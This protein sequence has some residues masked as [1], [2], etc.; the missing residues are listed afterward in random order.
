[1]F[2]WR[3]VISI[4][5]MFKN[6][7]LYLIFHW[8]YSFWSSSYKEWDSK[9]TNSNNLEVCGAW[10][11]AD[12]WEEKKLKVNTTWQG[13]DQEMKASV[14]PM[15]SLNSLLEFVFYLYKLFDLQVSKNKDISQVIIS[16]T[17]E[18]LPLSWTSPVHKNC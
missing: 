15:H 6:R 1:M 12:Q 13:T 5:S 7:Q 17:N 14:H 3:I 4:V 18:S 8:M 11:L 10:L 16:Y 2:I 9:I